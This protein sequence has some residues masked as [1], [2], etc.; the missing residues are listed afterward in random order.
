MKASS[1]PSGGGNEEG[2]ASGGFKSK[3][4][5]LETKNTETEYGE[6]YIHIEDFDENIDETF[7]NDNLMPYLKDLYRD[8]MMRSS[9]PNHLDKV[10]FIEY[11]KLPGI[12]NDRLHYMFSS[13]KST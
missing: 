12:I 7:V 6:E 8:L 4:K 11:T 13:F 10:T 3:L 1:N 9:N 5:P 2:K